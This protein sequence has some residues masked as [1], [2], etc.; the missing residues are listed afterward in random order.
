MNAE[1]RQ[2]KQKVLLGMSGGTDSSIAAI[3][4]Q[5]Q[6]YEVLG[7]TFR[8]YEKDGQTDYLEAARALADK[9]GIAHITYDVR[10]DFETRIIRYFIDSYMQGETPVPCTLC[11]NFFKWPLMAK[12]AD[13]Q[14]IDYISTGHYIQRVEHDGRYYIRPGVDPDK[15]QSFFMW[16]LTQELMERMI[17][18][19]G[20]MTKEE[21]RA[22]ARE[23]GYAAQA[24]K[25]ESIGVCFCPGDYRSFLR[26]RIAE[27][28]FQP[29]HFVDLDGQVLGKH[30]GFPF[31]TV[32]QRRGLGVHF[33]RALYVQNLDVQ[34]NRV[35]LAPLKDLERMSFEVRDWCAQSLDEL[36]SIPHVEVRIRYRKQYNTGQ[37]QLVSSEDAAGK[38]RLLVKLDQPLTAVAAGQAVAFYYDN[39]VI[40][41]GII[42]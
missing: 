2:S 11:N 12:V 26:E 14:G 30:S 35:T 18:P 22:Y 34:T 40:G 24:D 39:R 8:F 27:D 37:V 25:K 5:E 36:L 23:R 7:I 10:E 38:K 42:C 13:E 1:K 6:G 20:E 9:L 16:G 4:L 17:L 31:F 33:N 28:Q 41:G 32:G 19:L 15:D 3:M 21:V 29:G